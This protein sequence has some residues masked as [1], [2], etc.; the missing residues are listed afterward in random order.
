MKRVFVTGATGFIGAAVAR[1][2]VADG[3]QVAVLVRPDANLQRLGELRDRLHLIRGS[4]D[5]SATYKKSL[6]AFCPDTVMH[7]GWH[8][9]ARNKRE[10]PEQVRVN[11]A[12]SVDLLLAAQRSG[13]RTFLGAGSQAEY[14][15]CPH[16]LYENSPIGPKTLYGAAK[17]AVHGL[18]SHIANT[19]GVAF[20]W[21]RIFSVYGPEDDD[22]TFVS[23]VI[24]EL[25]HGRRPAVS[26]G[27][28]LWDY[29]Y[30]ED[31]AR[32]F[33]RI[34]ELNAAGV[35]NVASGSPRPLKETAQIIRDEIDPSL[36]IGFGEYVDACPRPLLASVDRLLALGWR[37]LISLREGLRKTIESRRAGLGAV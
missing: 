18:L 35:Y 24:T 5:S 31:A 14:E 19:H 34:A 22:A 2:L 3:Y 37:P 7:L 9:V 8:G 28:Q 13:C 20:S 25:L 6:A 30:I 21:L 15:P 29:L 1:R 16:F 36:E 12:G 32:A 17:V 4:L 11:V 33:V 27:D 10:D 23:Y 26:A